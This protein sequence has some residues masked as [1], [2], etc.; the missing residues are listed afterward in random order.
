MNLTVQTPD[1]RLAALVKPKL[2]TVR[3]FEIAPED[4]LVVCAGFEDR[5]MGVLNNMALSGVRFNVLMVHYEPFFPENRSEA[6][7]ATCQR[8]QINVVDVIYNRQEPAGFGQLLLEKLSVCRGRVFVDISAMSRLL[9]VQII[10]ALGTQR[11]GFAECFIAYAEA[12]DYPPR[13]AEAEAELAKCESDPTFSVLFLSSG[14]FDITVLPE[15]S[16]FAPAGTQARLIAFPSLDGHQLTALRAEIQPSRLSLMEG[17]PPDPKNRWRQ[18]VISI[19]NCLDQI[20]NAERFQIST[21]DYR[22]TLDCLLKLYSRHSVRERLIISPTG[23]K[24]QTV[25]VGL[26]RAAVKDVQ[27]VYPT[28]HGFLKPDSYTL[29]VGSLHVLPLASFSLASARAE[30]IE[31]GGAS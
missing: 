4:W 6:M 19:L 10:V 1:E 31:D 3:N 20:E 14:V 11:D 7:R 13:Q 28:P 29:G 23:S 8:S 26:F 21:L 18:R 2:E 12:K 25:A 9:I 5:A 16:S 22:E 24:M 27:I 17:V 15:L 30:L